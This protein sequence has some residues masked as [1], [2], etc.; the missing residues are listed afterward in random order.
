MNIVE[1]ETLAYYVFIFQLNQRNNGIGEK[2]LSVRRTVNNIIIIGLNVVVKY[3][4]FLYI[5]HQMFVDI[6]GAFLYVK[7]IFKYKEV[8]FGKS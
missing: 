1:K 8:V 7:H 5:T 4:L 3:G 6:I 2:L